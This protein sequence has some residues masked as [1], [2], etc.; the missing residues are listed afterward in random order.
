MKR[1]IIPKSLVYE[2]KHAFPNVSRT[3]RYALVDYFQGRDDSI[4]KA[5]SGGI[6]RPVCGG[7]MMI[8]NRLAERRRESQNVSPAW[9]DQHRQ[10]LSPAHPPFEFRHPIL[11]AG[12]SREDSADA[13]DRDFLLKPFPAQQRLQFLYKDA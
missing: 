4:R 8:R 1:F 6:G 10:N 7:S 3:G 11:E 5:D 12:F 9:T 13:E 2:Q